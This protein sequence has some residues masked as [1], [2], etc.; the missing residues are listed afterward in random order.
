MKHLIALGGVALLATALFEVAAQQPPA[1]GAA[2]SPVAPATPATASTAALPSVTPVPP[3]PTTAAP[4]ALPS[5]AKVSSRLRGGGSALTIPRA[6]NP[7][8]PY[9]AYTPSTTRST[10]APLIIQFSPSDPAFAPAMEEDLAIMTRLFERSLDQMQEI[11]LVSKL[12]IR[13]MFTSEARSVRASY[14][15]GLGALFMV[16]VNFPVFGAPRTAEMRQAAPPDS[17]WEKAKRDLAGGPSAGVVRGSDAPD[18]PEYDASLVGRLTDALVATLKNGSNIRRIKPEEFITVAVFGS[19]A[20]GNIPG[21]T[22]RLTAA[23][24]KGEGFPVEAENLAFPARVPSAGRAPQ[25]EGQGAWSGTVLTLRAKRS[26]VDAF[27][28]DE[29]NA[30]AF[31]AR[32]GTHAY[33]GNGYGIT[34]FNSWVQE[35]SG[36]PNGEPRTR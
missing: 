22:M 13:F 17:E 5:P 12:G 16:K 10:V 21:K 34:S 25:L 14:V 28:K 19:P 7:V 2:P 4:S 18:G 32:V 20:I 11:P 33:A 8:A 23:P 26:D 27:A 15:E 1:P 30:E 35:G 9:I 24:P 31:R 6:N 3:T 36:S 29:L